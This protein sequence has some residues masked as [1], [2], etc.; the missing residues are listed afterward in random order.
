MLALTVAGCAGE[1]ERAPV[2]PDPAA[3]EAW[4]GEGTEASLDGPVLEIRGT[5]P[6]RFLERGGRIWARSGPFLYLFNVHV[7]DLLVDYPDLAGVRAVTVTEGGEEIARAL[8]LRGELHRY[9]W[10]EALARASLAQTQG[11]E[12]PRRLEELIEWG[13][14]HTEYRYRE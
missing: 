5:I 4:F 7:R 9:E 8:L 10:R 11:T 6:D 3:V 13:E 1:P 14:E 12:S 2:L